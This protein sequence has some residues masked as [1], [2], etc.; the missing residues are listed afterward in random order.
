MLIISDYHVC[1]PI[2]SC[3]HIDFIRL[4]RSIIATP[5]SCSHHGQSCQS[6]IS[7]WTIPCPVRPIHPWSTLATISQAVGKHVY[8]FHYNWQYSEKESVIVL[9]GSWTFL[10]HW[11]SRR[12]RVLMCIKQLPMPWQPTL[13]RVKTQNKKDSCF[14][15]LSRILARLWTHFTRDYKEWRNRAVF[16]IS[17]QK[18]NRKS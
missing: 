18:S 12:V 1:A 11:L 9:F 15:M 5:T 16:M 4:R 13:P 3:W 2:V 6:T 8:R 7:I 14:V 10:I 17:T